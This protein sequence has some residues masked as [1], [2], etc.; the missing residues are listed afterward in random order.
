[1]DSNS[2]SSSDSSSSVEKVSY[3]VCFDVDGFTERMTE[4]CKQKCCREECTKRK[5]S[6]QAISRQAALLGSLHVGPQAVRR[7]HLR[8]HMQHSYILTWAR[9]NNEKPRK[10]HGTTYRTSTVKQKLCLASWL[11]LH[12]IT[13]RTWS[14]WVATMEVLDPKPPIH[15]HVG[16]DGDAANAFKEVARERVRSFILRVADVEGH[17]VPVRRRDSDGHAH[18]SFESVSEQPTYLPPKYTKRGL[19]RSYLRAH[20]DDTG[21]SW[22]C[23]RSVLN[24]MKGVAV[25]KRQR[26]LCDVCFIYRDSMRTLRNQEGIDNTARDFA[27]HLSNADAMLQQYRAS[28]ASAKI[29]WK[30]EKPEFVVLAFDYARQLGVPQLSDETTEGFWASKKALDVNLFGIVNEGGGSYGLGTPY[31][32]PERLKAG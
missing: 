8:T 11:A 25:S 18:F 24:S 16:R 30:K 1:M 26:G 19:Y 9:D 23:F 20:S 13:D 22:S 4:F 3:R 15:G 12:D 6:A 2:D 17:A 32:L 10:K 29:E 27:A 21:V 14:R 31:L 7:F 28:K 5:I